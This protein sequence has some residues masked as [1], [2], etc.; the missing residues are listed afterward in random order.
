[1]GTVLVSLP[2]GAGLVLDHDGS[3]VD[4]LGEP[5]RPELISRTFDRLAKKAGLR[6]LRL[7]DLRHTAASLMLAAGESP[8]VVT[9]ILGHSSP[10]ITQIIY[11]HL[12]PGMSDAAGERLTALL[13]A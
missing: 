13:E 5:Y 4:E 3:I 11:Q 2:L 1:M 12:M 9:E 10:I 6:R 8:K 7:H